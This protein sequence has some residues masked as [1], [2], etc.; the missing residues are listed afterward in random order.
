MA[1]GE[2][3][4]LFPI[5]TARYATAYPLAMLL[6][7]LAALC[8]VDTLRLRSQHRDRRRGWAVLRCVDD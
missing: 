1:E 4:N 5:S 3:P 2:F 7:I 6:R 8:D